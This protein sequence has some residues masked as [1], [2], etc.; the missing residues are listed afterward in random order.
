MVTHRRHTSPGHH[1]VVA[2]R[3][4]S[5]LPSGLP[6]QALVVVALAGLFMHET[7]PAKQLA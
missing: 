2:D 5:A 7:A 6:P 1:R 4:G 3:T